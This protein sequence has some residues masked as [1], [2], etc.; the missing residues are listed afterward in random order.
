M[1]DPTYH[2]MFP[3]LILEKKDPNFDMV[4]SNVEANIF[5]HIDE[6][7]YTGEST[8]F[9]TLHQDPAFNFLFQFAS[10][11][12]KDYVAR[13]LIDPEDFDFYIVK[14]W[15][16]IIKNRSIPMHSHADAH[17]SF[18]Y[19]VNVPDDTKTPLVFHNN[20]NRYEP[21][22]GLTRWNSN[23]WDPVN[24]GS[25]AFIPNPGSIMVFPAK[26][27]HECP[28]TSTG[29]DDTGV[30]DLDDVRQHRVSIAGDIILTYKEK[31]NKALG[32]QPF[33]NWQKF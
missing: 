22:T 31:S 5:N 7:G 11:A 24:S 25:W 23:E 4:K 16:N 32:L 10:E 33:E 3:T 18:V 29:P 2:Y 1:T 13:L 30:K 17:L 14:S 9:V 27:N 26:M 19:Y 21:F 28:C 12:A 15:A 8:G 20:P 6:H